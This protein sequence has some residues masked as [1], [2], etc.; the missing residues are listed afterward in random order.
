MGDE[1]FASRLV[2]EN[3][4]FVLADYHDLET[5]REQMG[6]LFLNGSVATREDVID[7][8][9]ELVGKVVR[10]VARTLAW[11]DTHS[12]R[13]MVDALGLQDPMEQSA[14]LDVLKVQKRIYSPDGRISDSQVASVT[15]FLR[16]TELTPAAQRF[17]VKSLVNARWAGTAP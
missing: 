3:V 8:R 1:P 17:D 10:A 12:A 9:P 11:M 15:R 16:A 4:A 13:D 14:L 7:S 2:K 6:G 5:T